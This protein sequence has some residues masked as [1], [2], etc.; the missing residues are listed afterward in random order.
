VP[1]GGFGAEPAGYF[2]LGFP[3][4]QVSFAPTGMFTVKDGLFP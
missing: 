4:P 3:G 1:G 2:L